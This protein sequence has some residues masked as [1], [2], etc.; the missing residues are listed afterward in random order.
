MQ[1]HAKW[2]GTDYYRRVPGKWRSA[3]TPRSRESRSGR[4]GVL[5]VQARAVVGAVAAAVGLVAGH[6]EQVQV[7]GQPAVRVVGAVGNAVRVQD[8]GPVAVL[9]LLLTAGAHFDDHS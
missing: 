4:G 7:G 6:H 8:R 3:V 1:T 9:Q 5:R 2:W